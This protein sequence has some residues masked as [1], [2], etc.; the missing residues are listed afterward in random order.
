MIDVD[1]SLD[2]FGRMLSDKVRMDAYSAAIVRAVRPGDAV[3]DL[4]CGP[5]V[6]ALLACKAGARAVYAIDTN[7]AVEFGRHLA[8]VNG[9]SDRIH[10][11]R[12]DC[13]QMHLPERVNVIVSDV[14]GV[15]P[16]FSQAVGTLEDARVR[17]LAEGGRLIPQR[18]VL[19]VAVVQLSKPYEQLTTG[20]ELTEQQIDLSSGLPLI[21]NSI[22]RQKLQPE[23]LLSEIRQWHTLNY[24]TGAKTSAQARIELPI[25]RGDVGHGL[26]IWFQTVLTDDI[27]YSSGSINA[28]NIYGQ[29]FL[30]WLEPVALQE[31]DVCCVDLR[32]H[33]VGNSYVWQWETNIPAAARR[34]QVHFRQSSFYGSL[35]PASL[36]QKRAVDFVPVLN[37]FGQAERWILQAMDG[38]RPL[39]EIAAEAARLYP[40]IFRR[41]E[42][43]F[44]QVAEIAEKF[45]R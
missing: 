10:F 39:H 25:L 29:T 44:N 11:M 38:K 32:A 9:Y 28:E 22:Y 16:L 20:W 36:L 18:D 3:V 37:E 6:F 17:F 12:G 40:H 14:R 1:Y 21:L 45:S 15:L 35:F 19:C 30:P 8:A 23:H 13:R 27:G 41:E 5:G 43:A 2:Q 33:L 34:E 4:G 7:G 42:E 26:G 24:D 31:G